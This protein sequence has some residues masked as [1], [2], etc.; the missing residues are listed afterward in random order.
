MIFCYGSPRRIS[1]SI[2]N[3]IFSRMITIYSMISSCLPLQPL[4]LP[5]SIH[6]IHDFPSDWIIFRSL[7]LYFLTNYY[8]N[9]LHG[10]QCDLFLKIKG[11]K[12][13]LYLICSGILLHWGLSQKFSFDPWGSVQL[14]C[15]PPFHLLLYCDSWSSLFHSQWSQVLLLPPALSPRSSPPL[16]RYA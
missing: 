15:Y 12:I 3:D 1:L 6:I 2:I 14:G 9:V 7:N 4:I 11:N 8:W 10:S 5:F 16:A 13:L